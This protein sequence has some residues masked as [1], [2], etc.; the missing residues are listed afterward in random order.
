[1]FKRAQ[2]QAHEHR[3]SEYDG[4]PF[5]ECK[6]C[7]AQRVKGFAC[8]SC[9]Y[10]PEPRGEGIDYVDEQLVELTNTQREALD[11]VTFY[12]E[13][14]ERLQPNEHDTFH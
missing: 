1:M 12:R 10:Q 8:T 5:C 4:D 7:G 6:Q 14:L 2:N 9:G 13:L 11:A 3:K